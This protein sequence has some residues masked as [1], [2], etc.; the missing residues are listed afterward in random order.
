MPVWAVQFM[1]RFFMMPEA[2]MWAKIKFK[3]KVRVRSSRGPRPDEVP[4]SDVAS[5]TSP[6]GIVYQA[7]KTRTH[8]R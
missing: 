8:R 2:A 1:W 5:D 3:G 6:F 4:S 7:I